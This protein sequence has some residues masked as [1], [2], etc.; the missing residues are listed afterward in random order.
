MNLT[1]SPVREINSSESFSKN[2]GSRRMKL[3]VNCSNSKRT[4]K[5][6]LSGFHASLKGNQ[7]HRAHSGASFFVL[8]RLSVSDPLGA[9]A[10]R[11]PQMNGP[12]QR[13]DETPAPP[14]DQSQYATE[15][16]LISRVAKTFTNTQPATKP[17]ICAA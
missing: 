14:A 1:S 2:M 11:P 12:Q 13:E 8:G 10:S 6:S 17:P 7:K 3:S 15:G 4:T 16:R 5:T 9:R